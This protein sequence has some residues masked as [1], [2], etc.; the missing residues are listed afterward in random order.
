VMSNERHDE[1]LARPVTSLHLPDGCQGAVE[2]TTITDPF[3]RQWAA[4]VDRVLILRST[5][6]SCCGCGR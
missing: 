6:V 5:S 1:T 2:M 4:L 3:A